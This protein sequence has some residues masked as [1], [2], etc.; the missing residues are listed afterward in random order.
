MHHKNIIKDVIFDSQVIIYIYHTIALCH[1]Q[2]GLDLSHI[3]MLAKDI[4]SNK[5]RN[6]MYLRIGISYI[7]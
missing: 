1:T 5:T 6:Y 7:S 2:T 4:L 3:V